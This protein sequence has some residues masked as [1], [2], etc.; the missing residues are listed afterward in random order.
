MA[1]PG[2]VTQAS[3]SVMLDPCICPL[4]LEQ[5]PG[6]GAAG[7]YRLLARKTSI[8]LCNVRARLCPLQTAQAAE[9]YSIHDAL[10]SLALGTLTLKDWVVTLALY[11]SQ[12]WL[13]FRAGVSHQSPPSPL[14]SNKYSNSGREGS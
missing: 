1:V 12:A 11:A 7:R 8:K 3:S 5:I 4:L 9:W 10:I 13:P 2:V 6:S 14:K